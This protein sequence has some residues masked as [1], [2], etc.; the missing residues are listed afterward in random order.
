[1]KKVVVVAAVVL[2][3]VFFSEFFR[4][5]CKTGRGWFN[6]LIEAILD[7]SKTNG[8]LKICGPN[9]GSTHAIYAYI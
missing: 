3:Q 8:R 9:N 1:M 6:G 5:E 4:R 2:R 7:P